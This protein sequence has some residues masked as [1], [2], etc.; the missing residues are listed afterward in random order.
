M[1]IRTI[2]TTTPQPNGKFGEPNKTAFEKINA[3]FADMGTAGQVDTSTA[4]SVGGVKTFLAKAL[5]NLGLRVANNV[6]IELGTTGAALRGTDTGYAD[7]GSSG[8]ASTLIRL[9]PNGVASAVGQVTL[10]TAGAMAF[11]G[12]AAAKASTRASLGA[13]AIADLAPSTGTFANRPTVANAQGRLYYATDTQEVYSPA[14]GTWVVLPSGTELGYAQ[15][16]TQ[17]S[18]TSTAFVDVPGLTISY[19]AGVNPAVVQFG[20]TAK[21]VTAATGVVALIVDGV[22]IKQILIDSISF[23]SFFALARIAGKTPG[24]TVNVKLQVRNAGSAEVQLFG[25]TTDPAALRVTTG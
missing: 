18:T 17:F 12:N 11:S 24:A 14:T 5:F 16:T 6:N 9:R 21:V 19:V 4:Q 8:G 15:R 13:P 25:D 22:Q 20:A 10:D 23:T 3:N 1:A 7:L 2:D